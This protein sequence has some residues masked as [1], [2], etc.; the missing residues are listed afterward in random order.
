MA[1]RV[2]NAKEGRESVDFEIYG[3]NGIPEEAYAERAAKKARVMEANGAG[4]STAGKQ[5]KTADGPTTGQ[6]STNLTQHTPQQFGVQPQMPGMIYGQPMPGM[7]FH[8]MTQPGFQGVA[9][10]PRPGFSPLQPGMSHMQH[11]AP[12][13]PPPMFGGPHGPT[14]PYQ[15][16]YGAPGGRPQG[17]STVPGVPPG[18]GPH[19]TP[20]PQVSLPPGHKP[21]PA[22]PLGI[23]ASQNGTS[24]GGTSSAVPVAPVTPLF[25][26]GATAPSSESCSTDVT[27]KSTTAR[28]RQSRCQ[29]LFL[30]QTRFK[31]LIPLSS[32]FGLTNPGCGREDAEQESFVANDELVYE[33]YQLSMHGPNSL[34]IFLSIST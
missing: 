26:A 21:P 20:P 10:G 23:V 7:G 15:G 17:Y 24:S 14:G 12:P 16:M 1:F 29:L 3:I 8:P 33:V 25:P 9:A 5:E 11:G 31:S 27:P 4:E 34:S 13:I 22:P 19:G 30:V 6:S 32:Y 28:D 18:P 2:P